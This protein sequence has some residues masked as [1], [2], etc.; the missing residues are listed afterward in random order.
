MNNRRNFLRNSLMA[1]AIS[2]LPKVLQ[3]AVPEVME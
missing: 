2:I 3:P 1:I